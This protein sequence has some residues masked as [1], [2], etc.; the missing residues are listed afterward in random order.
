MKGTKIKTFTQFL[1]ESVVG[2]QYTETEIREFFKEKFADFRDDI[3]VSMNNKFPLDDFEM[4]EDENK[5][6]SEYFE[7]S[8]DFLV[9]KTVSGIKDFD[10]YW[11]DS[12]IGIGDKV[13][14]KS[15][16]YHVDKIENGQIY[17]KDKDVL[18]PLEKAEKYKK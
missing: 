11:D 17:D 18:I 8:I 5:K 2:E 14:Y 9:D 10:A 15:V 4:S 7:K 6:L 1:S 13:K 12:K 3:I 16:V